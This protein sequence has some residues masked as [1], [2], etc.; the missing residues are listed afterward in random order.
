[1]KALPRPGWRKNEINRQYDFSGLDD[2]NEKGTGVI[3]SFCRGRC[4]IAIDKTPVSF[5]SLHFV[6]TFVSNSGT[7]KPVIIRETRDSLG[8]E[9]SIP[10]DSTC[11]KARSS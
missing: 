3:L 4:P 7:L 10:P 1:M 9:S 2:P 6:L 11:L 5:S 8:L